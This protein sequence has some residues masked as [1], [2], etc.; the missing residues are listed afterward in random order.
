MPDS[1]PVVPP[2]HLPS[3]ASK[4]TLPSAS[5]AC[6][7]REQWGLAMCRNPRHGTLWSKGNGQE[8]DEPIKRPMQPSTAG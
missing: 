1:G 7:S 3:P 4:T 5:T 6:I 2:P 8:D